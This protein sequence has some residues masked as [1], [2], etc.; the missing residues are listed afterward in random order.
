MS[1][2]EPTSDESIDDYT[3]GGETWYPVDK[4]CPDCGG[5][6]FSNGTIHKCTGWYDH[7][8]R[9]CQWWGILE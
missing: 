9:D 5:N 2:R 6:C 1:L 4:D 8:E 7:N 3:I